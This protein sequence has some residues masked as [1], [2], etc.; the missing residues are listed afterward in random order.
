MQWKSFLLKT[1]LIKSTVFWTY[2][3]ANKRN[4]SKKVLCLFTSWAMNA[5]QHSQRLC[6][7][8]SGGRKGGRGV[9][10]GADAK[11]ARVQKFLSRR[12]NLKSLK[13]TFL[14]RDGT[15]NC[16]NGRL[17]ELKIVAIVSS[18]LARMSS[19]TKSRH[20]GSRKLTHW[21]H[22]GAGGWFSALTSKWT[23]RISPRMRIKTWRQIQDFAQLKKSYRQKVNLPKKFWRQIW[24]KDGKNLMQK[25]KSILNPCYTSHWKVK[26]LSSGPMLQTNF[27]GCSVKTI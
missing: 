8:S 24:V 17:V 15:K 25:F 21:V 2:V 6:G 10:P 1:F 4:E 19:E 18:V 7:R 9:A 22:R 11:L 16:N 5:V 23:W 12:K 26:G 20:W 27:N 3:N 14:K 13:R